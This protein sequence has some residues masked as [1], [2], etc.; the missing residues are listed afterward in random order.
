MTTDTKPTGLSLKSFDARKASET[1]FEFEY[2]DTKGTHT[3]LFLLVLGGHCETVQAKANALTNE[4]RRQEAIA[5]ADAAT[6]RAADNFTP[7][8]DDVKF[9]QR[10]A[11]IRLVGWRGIPEPWTEA[12]GLWLCQN[13]PDLAMQVLTKSN[14]MGNFMRLSAKD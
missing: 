1:P 13:N 5:A 12:D 7:V 2:I 14:D 4:R 11:A 8:E 10:L 3:G 6:S 9:G